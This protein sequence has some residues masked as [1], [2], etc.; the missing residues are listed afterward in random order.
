MESLDKIKNFFNKLK[1]KQGKD[2][3]KY[4]G[5]IFYHLY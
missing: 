2:K 3:I 1:N 4:I 5:L